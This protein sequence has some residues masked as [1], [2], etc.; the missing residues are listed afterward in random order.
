MRFLLLIPFVSGLGCK[1]PPDAPESLDEL[2]SYIYEH[3][4]DEEDE[5]L[6][7]GLENL[8]PWLEEHFEETYEGYTITNLSQEAVLSLDGV[9][10]DLTSLLGAA[11]GFDMEAKVAEVVHALL[12]E[13]MGEI[14]EGTYDTYEREFSTDRDCFLDRE[15]DSVELDIHVVANYPL[16][17]EVEATSRVQYRRVEIDGEEAIVQ[18]TWMLEPGESNKDWLTI[19]QQYFLS[20]NLPRDGATRRVD[21]MWVKAFLGEGDVPENF[22]LQV[23]IDTMRSTGESIDAYLASR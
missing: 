12:S 6:V 11:V 4:M 3:V 9:E 2:C 22:A 21:A 10:R 18:R 1:R 15:C 23:A 19:D 7:A 13:D 17:L 14:F 20:V 5:Y 16:G 8:V